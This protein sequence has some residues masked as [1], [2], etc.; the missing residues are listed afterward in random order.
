MWKRGSIHTSM[1]IPDRYYSIELSSAFA[2]LVSQAGSTSHRSRNTDSNCGSLAEQEGV[3]EVSGI[4]RSEGMDICTMANVRIEKAPSLHHFLRSHCQP[5]NKGSCTSI[6]SVVC[7]E[8]SV[9]Y[10]HGKTR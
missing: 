5:Q 7:L 3:R 4:K 1:I 6:T 10:T 2:A 9:S 8:V